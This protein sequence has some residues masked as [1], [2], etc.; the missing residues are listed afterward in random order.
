MNKN[1]GLLCSLNQSKDDTQ[2]R[3]KNGVESRS[4]CSI[5]CLQKCECKV[6]DSLFSFPHSKIL[7]L[8]VPWTVVVP[9]P[10]T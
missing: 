1:N 6:L 7:L 9:E 8:V 10:Y 5:T 3:V 2:Q 4:T